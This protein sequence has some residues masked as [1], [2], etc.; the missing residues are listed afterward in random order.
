MW[1]EN[2]VSI[3]VAGSPALA[4]LRGRGAEPRVPRRA[5]GG[6]G[7]RRPGLHSELPASTQGRLGNA[8]CVACRASV[9]HR[10]GVA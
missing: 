6:A 8:G 7:S 10:A 5:L 3:A 2:A 4:Q 9:L 1:R